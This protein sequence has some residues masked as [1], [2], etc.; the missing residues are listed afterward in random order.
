M[1][2][3]EIRY[4]RAS[5]SLLNAHGAWSVLRAKRYG[6]AHGE[7]SPVGTVDAPVGTSYVDSKN[8]LLYFK[9]GPTV[10]DWKHIGK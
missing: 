6:R 8:K 9:S 5:D 7:G 2:L 10:N 4:F 1:F 3:Q